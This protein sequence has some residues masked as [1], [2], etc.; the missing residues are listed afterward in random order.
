MEKFLL[1]IRAM[2][3]PRVF[4]I[5]PGKVADEV[6]FDGRFVLRT[7]ASLAPLQAVLR[8]LD[9]LQEVEISQGGERVTLRTPTTGTAGRLFQAA[10]V[11]RPPQIQDHRPA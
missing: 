11:A 4:E 2:F 5:D 6:R 7:K 3:E 8:D 9:R 10:G 1:S